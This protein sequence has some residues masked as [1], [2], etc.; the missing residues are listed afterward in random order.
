MIV[1]AKILHSVKNNHSV[2]RSITEIV[3]RSLQMLFSS[4][5]NIETLREAFIRNKLGLSCAKLRKV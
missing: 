5:L 3:V 2:S 1:R 4:E